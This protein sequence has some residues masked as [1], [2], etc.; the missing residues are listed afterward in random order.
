MQQNNHDRKRN[1]RV[2]EWSKRDWITGAT[3]FSQLAAQQPHK[4]IAFEAEKHCRS[5]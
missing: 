5:N 2:E 1:Y 3:A 4:V